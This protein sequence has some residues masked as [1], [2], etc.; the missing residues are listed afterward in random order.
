M[1]VTPLQRTLRFRELVEL[2]LR[3]SG[4]ENVRRT[5]PAANLS[6]AFATPESW[7]DFAGFGEN[8]I[9]EARA[10]KRWLPSESLDHAR[11]TADLAGA[12]YSAVVQYRI[13]RPIEQHYVLMTLKELGAILRG[14]DLR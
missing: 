10:Q 7:G 5:M 4:V 8:F 1:T 2:Q 14:E 9:L 11:K 13:D 3:A 12:A 6:E